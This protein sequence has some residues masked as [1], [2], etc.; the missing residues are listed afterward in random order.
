MGKFKNITA[1]SYFQTNLPP[2][3]V[4]WDGDVIGPVRHTDYLRQ[5]ELIQLAEETP[6]DV[7]TLFEVAKG[8]YAYGS[9]YWPLFTVANHYALLAVEAALHLKYRALGGQGRNVTM[10]VTIRF[11]QKKLSLP[12]GMRDTL[13]AAKGLRD[14]LS[15]QKFATISGPTPDIL[16][17]C[18]E[19]I[20]F[21]F[22]G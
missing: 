4:T 17:R 13:S 9:L 5:L 1:E 2:G 20:D 3:L 12:D 6:E 7:A 22:E 10:G 11:L 18:A 16:Q 8:A 21:L 15:H 19:V 14:Q